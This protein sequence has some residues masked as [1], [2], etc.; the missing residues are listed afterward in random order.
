MKKPVLAL[1]CLVLCIT[2]QT[3]S[4]VN[5]DTLTVRQLEKQSRHPVVNKLIAPATDT[6]DALH[7]RLELGIDPEQQ[8]VFGKVAIDAASLVSGLEQLELDLVALTVDSVFSGAQSLP[9]IQIGRI[10]QVTL[11]KVYAAAETLHTTIYYHGRPVAEPGAQSW[12][13]FYFYGDNNAFTLGAGLNTSYI[14]MTRHWLPCHDVP[15][16]KATFDMTFTVPHDKYLA[17]NGRLVE[18]AQQFNG[19][20]STATFRWVEEHPMATYLV[21]LAMRDYALIETTVNDTLPVVIYATHKDSA[22]SVVH[23]DRVPAMVTIY[24]ELFGAYPYDKVGYAVTPEGAMEHQTCIAYPEYVV[25]A[26]HTYDDLIAHELAHHWWG[27]WLSPGDWRDIWLNEGFATY[28]EALFMEKYHGKDRYDEQVRGHMSA[29]FSGLNTEGDFPIYDPQ[30]MWGVHSYEKAGCVLHMLRNVI[31]DSLFF[32]TLLE[33]GQRFAHSSVT[34]PDFINV[35]EEISAQDL[36]WF[37]NEWIYGPGYPLYDHSWSCVPTGEGDYVLNVVVKQAREDSLL[38]TMPLEIGVRY[39]EYDTT[40]AFMMNGPA[41]SLQVRLPVTVGQVTIDPANKILNK[42]QLSTYQPFTIVDYTIDDE[43]AGDGDGNPEAGEGFD[44]DLH[45]KSSGS[46]VPNLSVELTS[47]DFN[48]DIVN[49]SVDYGSMAY[50]QT[51]TAGITHFTIRVDSTCG[52]G[53]VDLTARFFINGLPAGSA[54]FSLN[55]YSQHVAYREGF[56]SIIRNW[57]T[58]NSW[59]PYFWAHSGDFSITDSPIAY[60]ES[61]AENILTL[62]QT[63][64][65]AGRQSAFLEFYHISI[66]ANGDSALVQARNNNNAWRTLAA[67]T[68]ESSWDWQRSVVDL[69]SYCQPGNQSVQVRFNLKS[70][71]ADVYDGWYIDDILIAVDSILTGIDTNKP[72]GLPVTLAL[73]QNHPNP[74]NPETVISFALP[75]AERVQV[76][77]YNS[78][79]QQVTTLLNDARAAGIHHLSWNGR[80]SAGLPVPSGVYF[81]RLSTDKQQLTRKMLLLR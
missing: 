11:D 60:Y 51:K 57:H 62:E 12:G 45:I 10:V 77:V 75:Q 32:A 66:L 33:Y 63:L 76:E 26:S 3:M 73:L 5:S 20:D 55:I 49:K 28:A 29:Y 24:S 27:D 16:D 19:A 38:F 36:D 25:S 6:W 40:L 7:Y 2:G 67:F 23:F 46:A 64:N 69:T 34:T 21:C 56:E 39:G 42:D 35:V 31:G 68:G 74:F 70:D 58:G 78:L 79:G 13:G 61:N 18:N 9:F 4:A 15:W 80:D 47:H 48:I 41:H 30:V 65:L 44:L 1:L 52:L 37:F 50:L 72:T 54:S 59:Q 17:S 71:A 81:Y 14:S 22:K 43:A 53:A 8:Q